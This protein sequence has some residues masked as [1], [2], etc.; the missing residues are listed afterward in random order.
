MIAGKATIV[1]DTDLKK[2]RTGMN[3]AKKGMFDFKRIAETAIGFGVANAA[4]MAT[5]AV[6]NFII[7]STKAA[8]DA[9]EIFSKFGFVFESIGE[10]AERAAKHLHENFGLANVTAKELLGTTGSLLVGFGLTEEA[11]LEL[12]IQT[13]ELAVDLASFTNLQGGAERASHILNRALVGERES[14]KSLDTVIL[15]VDIKQRL[16]E[17]GQDK[18]TGSA[19]RQA[20]A[21]ATIALVIEQ[22]KKVMGDFGRTSD[23]AA[24]QIKL[25]GEAWK[26][27]MVI[28]GEDIIPIVLPIIKALTKLIEKYGEYVDW[29]DKVKEKR[30]RRELESELK[31]EYSVSQFERGEI[32]SG[33]KAQVGVVP[34]DV[35]ETINKII[36][37]AFTPVV[38]ASQQYSETVQGTNE[39]LIELEDTTL[40]TADGMKQLGDSTEG[41][42]EGF[43]KAQQAISDFYDKVDW[44]GSKGTSRMEFERKQAAQKVDMPSSESYELISHSRDPSDPRSRELVRLRKERERAE[45][46]REM[47]AG[48]TY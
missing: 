45:A 29:I 16:M 6:K 37:E 36:D 10:E 12:A 33:I 11:A 17:K 23:E 31:E 28:F 13:Q 27:F 15:E 46:R 41:V 8:I 1:V 38:E 35:Q 14:L 34:E 43:S 25:L 3:Q 9:R 20:K 40:E 21:Q 19:L 30:E 32:V 39:N 24:G 4:M 7:E 48:N 42:I 47:E 22:N 44:F 18:L 26:D 2:F 5:S